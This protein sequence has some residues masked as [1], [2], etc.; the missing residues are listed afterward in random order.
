MRFSFLQGFNQS[1]NN[2]LRLQEATYFTQNQVSTGKRII[3]P[4]DDPI[5]SANLIQLRQEKAQLQQYKNNTAIAENRIKTEEVRLDSI[6]ELLI[7]TRELAVQAGN[8]VLEFGARQ[9]LGRELDARLDELVSIANAQDAN[10]EYIFGGFQGTRVPF[11]EN[12]DGSFTY[13]GD[14][15]QRTLKVSGGTSVA[16]SDSGRKVFENIDA[17]QNR[18]VAS[19][20]SSSAF[21]SQARVVTQATYDAS[22]PTDYVITFT[23]PG[24]YNIDTEAGVS[25]V[26]GAAYTSGATIAFNGIEF[27]ISGAV[28]GGDTFNIESSGK[29]SIMTTIRELANGLDTLTDST[30]DQATLAALIDTSLE[31]LL[32][33]ERNIAG[34]WSEVGAR[35]NILDSVSALNEGVD[36]VNTEIISELEDL[37]YA[38]ALSRLSQETFTLEAAQQ[39]FARV[40]SLSLFNFLR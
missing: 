33:A 40:T 11:V 2:L 21:I 28:A 10:G 35:A 20:G 15:G 26:A 31:N 27:E 12:A 19:V 18:A 38:E 34:I 7:R 32:A 9:A 23:G 14:D 39:S 25:I 29:Q 5:A 30:A 4:A 22:Y 24:T 37:D 3:T 1:V 16:I 17:A 6:N 36:L 8:G 13:Q